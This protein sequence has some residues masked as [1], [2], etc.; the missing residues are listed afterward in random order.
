M[1]NYKWT[2]IL[3]SNSTKATE[4]SAPKKKP[5]TLLPQDVRAAITSSELISQVNCVILTVLVG[6]FTKPAGTSGSPIKLGMEVLYDLSSAEAAAST[7][8]F[9]FVT[10]MSVSSRA[11]RNPSLVCCDK[12]IGN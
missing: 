12:E 11:F 5:V 7:V 10:I 1:T 2:G 4:S 9:R 6:F 3:A 8:T